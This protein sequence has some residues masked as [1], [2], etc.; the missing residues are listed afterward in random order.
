MTTLNKMGKYE[1]FMWL[2][3]E[4]DDKLKRHDIVE[5]IYNMIRDKIDNFDL[6]MKIDEDTFYRKLLDFLVD[7]TEIYK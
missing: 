1:L 3:H 6:S 7:N 2:K 5:I 4:Y